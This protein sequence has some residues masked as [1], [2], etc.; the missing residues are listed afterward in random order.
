MLIVVFSSFFLWFEVIMITK[1]KQFIL[2]APLP[3]YIGLYFGIITK[4]Y[5]RLKM[6]RQMVDKA[7]DNKICINSKD[8]ARFQSYLD[9]NKDYKTFKGTETKGCGQFIQ[10]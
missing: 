5:Q 9:G 8:C 3:L 6:E 7:C 1:K 2:M 10:K 4:K